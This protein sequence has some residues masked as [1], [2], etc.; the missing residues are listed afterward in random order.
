MARTVGRMVAELQPGDYLCCI[1]ESEEQLRAVLTP[2]LRRGLERGER[3]LYVADT[4]A[5]EEAVGC[6]REEGWDVERSLECGQLLLLTSDG[7]YAERGIFDPARMAALADRGREGDLVVEFLRAETERALKAGYSALR[8]AVDMAWGLRRLSGSIPSEKLMIQREAHLRDF[9]LGSRCLALCLYDRR[10][11]DPS[12]LLAVLQSHPVI[13]EGTE[14]YENFYYV[15]PEE[16]LGEG[17]AEAELRW[18]LKS[19]AERKRA[20]EELAWEQHLLNTLMDTI[21]DHIY[22][23]DT[24]SCFIRINRA[25]ARWLGLSDPAQALGKTDF[26][27]FSEEH[28]RQAYADE[29][30][31]M[32]TG[33]PIVGKE[34]KETWSDGRETWVSTTK[35]PLCD[36]EGRI[37]GTFG[38]SRDITERKRAEQEREKLRREQEEFYSMISHDLRTPL[39][40]IQGFVDLILQGRVSDPE[41]QREFLTRVA[42]QS[43][44]LITLVDE[45]LDLSRLETGRLELE[46]GEVQIQ[47]LVERV[48]DQLESV[49]RQKSISLTAQ[50]PPSLPPVEADSRRIEQVLT[51]LVGNALKFTPEGG[52][53][54]AK[55][56]VQGD[57]L[58]VQ[59]SDTGI[60]IPSEAMPHLFTKFYRGGDAS[61]RY[62]KGTGLGL[63]V[64]RRIV[65]AHGGRIWAES[66]P[67]RG[68]TFSFTLP[69]RPGAAS[70]RP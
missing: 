48:V 55:A 46:R 1:Y 9:F 13:A 60:G 23:K 34:E 18:C 7:A 53:V 16:L 64:S 22:F 30:E 42:R 36:R 67:G 26:D 40:S 45:L 70:D 32:R 65:E 20:Q 49:A 38:I 24:D 51:N 69:L 31:I 43:R 14:L 8:V 54:V 62:A 21:P 10:R 5:A 33:R 29:Q 28:A 4:R 44:R 17:R 58:V 15:P 63:Y 50:V 41:V 57:E 25:M 68:S 61:K 39:F 19:L 11:L 37:I 52:R 35:V 12:L 59:V 56:E 6:L 66:E 47:T 27:F 2:F 3:V